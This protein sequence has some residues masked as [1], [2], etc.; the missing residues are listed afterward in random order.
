[1]RAVA[2]ALLVA[3][4]SAFVSNVQSARGA[5]ALNLQSKSL[6]MIQAP[7]TLDGS[8]VGDVGFDPFQLS[9]IPFNMAEAIV[10]KARLEEGASLSMLYWMREAELKHGRICMLAFVGYVTVD[11]GIHFPG[12]KY[13]G[14]DALHA[15]NAMVDAGSMG[16]LL[17]VIGFIEI[18][19]MVALYEAANGSG[20]EAGDFAFD[21]L[22]FSKNEATKKDFQLKELKNVR[23]EREL[24]HGAASVFNGAR[25]RASALS[26][27]PPLSPFCAR[28]VASP[29]WLSAAL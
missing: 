11:A 23:L 2:L 15:H 12:A 8:M 6:P 16:F 10:P 26:F 22:G 24:A 14:I 9:M 28:R 27:P 17:L 7:P 19:S 29:C 18:I 20:R 1:M 25:A 5:T 13:Q 4:A 3:S 21:P